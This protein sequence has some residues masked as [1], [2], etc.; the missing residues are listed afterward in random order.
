E[1]A[2]AE[3]KTNHD[4]LGSHIFVSRRQYRAVHDTKSGKRREAAAR[5]SYSAACELGFRS[6]L[7]G[8]WAAISCNR[9]SAINS[10]SLLR[11]SSTVVHVSDCNG[12]RNGATL[13]SSRAVV[14]RG[15][16]PFS[17]HCA[18]RRK[19]AQNACLEL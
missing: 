17:T 8:A 3:L 1:Q 18:T 13:S 6:S 9:A 10:R 16:M 14:A 11:S 5:I 12:L 7:A 4:P 2:I 19:T 15:E